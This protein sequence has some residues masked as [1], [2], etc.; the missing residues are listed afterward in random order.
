MLG[1]TDVFLVTL[2]ITVAGHQIAC[3]QTYVNIIRIYVHHQTA[4][5]VLQAVYGN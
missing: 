1:R 5:S 3:V 4:L 2:I